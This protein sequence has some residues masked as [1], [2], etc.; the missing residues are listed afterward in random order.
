M[1]A[2][3]LAYSRGQCFPD[4]V[5]CNPGLSRSENKGSVTKFRYNMYNKKFW[6]ELIAYFP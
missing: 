4:G 6:E 5:Q 3:M 1:F 2:I